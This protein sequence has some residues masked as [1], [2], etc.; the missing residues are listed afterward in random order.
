MAAEAPQ[1][2]PWFITAPGQTDVL[3]VITTLVVILMVV[4]LGVFFFRL[5]SLPEQLGHKKLQWEV[6]AVLALISLFTHEHIF[7]IIALI[8]AL[9]DF[10]DLVSP[11]QRMAR[12][13]EKSAG[14]DSQPKVPPPPAAEMPPQG[15]EE[16]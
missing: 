12:A 8:L 7:W 4:L 1:H 16:A 6:V 14:L 13:L 10:P 3:Y 11:L 5:H 9:V 2:L 15:K